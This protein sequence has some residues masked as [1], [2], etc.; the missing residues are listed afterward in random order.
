MSEMTY[1][2]SVPITMEPDEVKSF[3]MEWVQ[4]NPQSS[5]LLTS[6]LPRWEQIAPDGEEPIVWEDGA[7]ENPEDPEQIEEAMGRLEEALS[8]ALSRAAFDR[9][10]E[11]TTTPD[12]SGAREMT[13][14]ELQEKV[15]QTSEPLARIA[16]LE[17]TPVSAW[18]QVGWLVTWWIQDSRAAGLPTPAW[19]T[20]WVM[21]LDPSWPT[22]AWDV[23]NPPQPTWLRQWLDQWAKRQGLTASS[24][25]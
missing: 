23:T 22:P 14:L 4:T 21:G 5:P 1:L 2:D 15:K 25:Q 19:V 7:M 16:L 11:L 13:L 20:A 24:Q 18:V 12:G 9:L 6:L 8:E 10:V 3:W 17:A